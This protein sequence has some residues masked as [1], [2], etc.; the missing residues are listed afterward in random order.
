MY[1]FYS[2]RR[3]LKLPN[4]NTKLHYKQ[5]VAKFKAN[6]QLNAINYYKVLIQ[7]TVRIHYLLVIKF[8]LKSSQDKRER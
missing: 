1:I 7:I 4:N 6:Q 8:Q 5:P 3:Q 2:S